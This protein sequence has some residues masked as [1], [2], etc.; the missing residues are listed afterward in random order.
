MQMI[1]IFIG[2]IIAVVSILNIA[3]IVWVNKSPFTHEKKIKYLTASNNFSKCLIV[4]VII[5]FVL[6]LIF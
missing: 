5:N 1:R 3:F 2:F 4:V 6:F